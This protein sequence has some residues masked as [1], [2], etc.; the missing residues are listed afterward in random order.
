M[1]EII[2]DSV[3]GYLVPDVA[4]AVLAVERAVALDR[5][6]VRNTAERRFGAA[7]MVDDYLTLYRQ[8]LTQ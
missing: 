2:D 8:L 3:T 7:R 5:K 1:P 4:A 6:V